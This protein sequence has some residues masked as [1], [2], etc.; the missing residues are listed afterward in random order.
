MSNE[1][2]TG[3]TPFDSIR[4]VDEQ[5]TEYWSARE[6]ATTLGY[7]PASW[8]NFEGVIKDAKI[9]CLKSGGDIDTNFYEVVKDSINSKRKYSVTDIHLTRYACYLVAQNADPSKPIVAQAQTYFAVMTRRQEVVE[10][11][12]V[13][14]DAR[15]S[16][17]E[18]MI[19]AAKA[20]VD[21]RAKLSES[22]NELEAIAHD[23]GMRGS[24]NIATLHTNGDIGM[25]TMPKDALAERHHLLPQRGH[26]KVNVNDHE[27]TLESGATIMR[28]GLARV[29]ISQMT[30]PTNPQMFRANREAGE[31]IRAVL[32]G[33]GIVPE[34][35]PKEPHISE[36]RKIANGQIPLELLPPATPEITEPPTEDY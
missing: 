32:L 19:A 12:T 30:A 17:I 24:R 34:D 3:Q 14:R 16:A 29:D 18:E 11:T 9:A 5:G 23:Q 2:T 15:T 6:L 28:N 35:M 25:Y 33:H 8:H 26:E 1:I 22:Y 31:E 10:S 36:A 7:K 20:R 27:G 21:A 4:H 13:V